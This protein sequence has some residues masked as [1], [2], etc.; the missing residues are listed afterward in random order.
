MDTAALNFVDP[1]L[2]RQLP[3]APG[4]G[5][6]IETRADAARAGREFEQMFI[7]QMMSQMFSGIK[8]DGMFGGG[9]GEEMFR[10]LQ[11]DE[12]ARA[13]TQHGGVGIAA[14]VTNELI[15]LQEASRG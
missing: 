9:F 14:S 11:V 15:R 2:T 5:T 4:Q 12:Y 1:S 3:R 6:A 10:S 8:T 13:L 7:S